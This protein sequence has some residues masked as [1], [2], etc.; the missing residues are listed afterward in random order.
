M[1]LLAKQH[2]NTLRIQKNITFKSPNTFIILL[3]INNEILTKI[4]AINETVESIVD[5][6]LSP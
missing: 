3:L 4:S 2:Q 6:L 5:L 1:V